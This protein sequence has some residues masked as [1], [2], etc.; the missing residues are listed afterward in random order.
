MRRILPGETLE[1]NELQIFAG[2]KGANQACAASLLGGDVRLAGSVGNDEFAERLLREL[3]SAGVNLELVL[4]SDV[5]SGSAT[6]LVLPNGK[7][8]IVISPG[9]NG[10]VSTAFAAEAVQTLEA[11]DLLLCQ[12]EI[13][14]KALEAPVSDKKT[15]S[16]VRAP[17]LA[18][19]GS[20][21]LRGANQRPR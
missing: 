12:L 7:N 15:G 6:I 9:A 18:A 10:E 2:G 5:A 3:R 16:C 20:P 1:G 11:G 17:S 19:L 8:T 13:R 14:V 21:G 4:R